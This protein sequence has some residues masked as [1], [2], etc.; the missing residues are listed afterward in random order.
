[1]SKLAIKQHSE[2]AVISLPFRW[3]R[4][5]ERLSLDL[6]FDLNDRLLSPGYVGDGLCTM[7]G[8]DAGDLVEEDTTEADGA[9]PRVAAVDA[10]GDALRAI[11]E[12]ALVYLGREWT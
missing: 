4:I 10:A 5:V 2:P 1:M 11:G 12:A 8:K 9:T 6:L 3:K 7:A